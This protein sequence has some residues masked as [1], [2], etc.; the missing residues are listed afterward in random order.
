M[1]DKLN[2]D[3]RQSTEAVEAQA[4]PQPSE[5]Q[6]WTTPSLTVIDINEKTELSTGTAFDGVGHS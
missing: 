1:N 5:K 6:P 2:L 3:P 4:Q